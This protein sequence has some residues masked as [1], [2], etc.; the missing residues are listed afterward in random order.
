MPYFYHAEI[1]N[2]ISESLEILPLMV[3]R[4]EIIKFRLGVALKL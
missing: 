4:V 2:E 1:M 3:M